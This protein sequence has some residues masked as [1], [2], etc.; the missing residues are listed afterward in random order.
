MSHFLMLICSLLLALTKREAWLGPVPP[1]CHI[2]IRECC[3]YWLCIE[4]VSLSSLF[5]QKWFFRNLLCCTAFW[6]KFQL[7]SRSSPLECCWF[8]HR[9]SVMGWSLSTERELAMLLLMSDYNSSNSGILYSCA[10]CCASHLIW[11][12]TLPMWQQVSGFKDKPAV[13]VTSGGVMF[14]L[15]GITV[16]FTPRPCDAHTPSTP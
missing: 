5:Y 1:I 12:L 11:S 8:L 13:T 7:T 2:S 10:T 15:A 14:P 4:S 3:V 9:I 6:H 16:R